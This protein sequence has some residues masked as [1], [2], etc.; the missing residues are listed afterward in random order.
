MNS[1]YRDYG[2]AST[3]PSWSCAYLLP[4]LRKML[5]TPAGAILDVGCGNGA[6]ARA[7]LAEGYDV[8]GVDASES[9]I[10]LANGETPGRFYLLD[11][12]TGEIPAAL[13][14][15][16][17]Q[18]VIST[19]VIEHLYEPRRLVAFARRMLAPEGRLIISTPYH[20]Y[21]KNL[22]LAISGRLDNHFTALW[23]GGHIKFFSRKTLEQL[24][25]EEGFEIDS[26]AGA[27][28]L[29]W[30]WRSMLVKARISRDAD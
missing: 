11:L 13:A 5:G 22:A 3:V 4:Q 12:N 7:L 15:R 9:G 29:V 25:R 6:T 24:L 28:R 17:F 26:F 10:E 1:S 23:D 2:H 18:F 14:G 16:A 21:L 30:L 27:G 8:F 20:G 19:E